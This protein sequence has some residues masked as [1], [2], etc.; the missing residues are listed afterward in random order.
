MYRESVHVVSVQPGFVYTRMTES[1]KLPPL[2]T[3]TP[4]Q[5]ADAVYSAIEKQEEHRLCEMV[6][7]LDHADNK[8]YPRIHVQ[9]MKL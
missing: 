8:I 1:I 3:A 5:V 4:E 9:K 2:L 7:A 6:L